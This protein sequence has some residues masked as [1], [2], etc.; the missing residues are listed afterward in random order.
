MFADRPSHSSLSHWFWDAY[1]ESD[2]SMTKLMLT[3][4][5]DKKAEELLPLARS[6]YHPPEIKVSQNLQ[7]VY[8]QTQRAYVITLQNSVK[9]IEC[10]IEANEQSPVVNPAFMFIDW[11]KKSV[12]LELNGKEMTRG[13]AFRL[14]HIVKLEGTDLIVWIEFE[15]TKPVQIKIVPIE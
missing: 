4:M 9:N 15:S 1:S 10:E 12:K 6:W 13:K 2:R 7:A 11:G 3:G 8:D 14:G 5:T